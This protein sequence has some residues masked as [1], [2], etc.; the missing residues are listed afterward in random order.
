VAVVPV[1]TTLGKLTANGAPAGV[2]ELLDVD[3]CPTPSAF[4]ATTEKV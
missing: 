1:A 3:G 2:T 4:V